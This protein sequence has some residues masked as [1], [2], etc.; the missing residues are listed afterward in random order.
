MRYGNQ[1]VRHGNQA[2]RLTKVLVRWKKETARRKN[3]LA[4]C[5]NQGEGLINVKE[6]TLA[7]GFDGTQMTLIFYDLR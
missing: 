4:R 6:E 3:Q 5:R 2:V 1:T 7:A